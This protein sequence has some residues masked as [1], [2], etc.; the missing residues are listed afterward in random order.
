MRAIKSN[1]ETKVG[2]TLISIFGICFIFLGILDLKGYDVLWEPLIVML[3]LTVIGIF[4]NV[5]RIIVGILWLAT[6][7]VIMS[8][9]T[10]NGWILVCSIFSA[11]FI[12]LGIF[13]K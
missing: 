2:Y 10:P 1:R 3:I 11:I 13:T 12:G 5:M 8:F 4:S 7:V 6:I 9:P